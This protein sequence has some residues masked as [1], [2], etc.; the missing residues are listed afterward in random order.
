MV[1]IKEIAVD[2]AYARVV[3]ETNKAINLLMALQPAETNAPPK[4]KSPVV[5]NKSPRWRPTDLI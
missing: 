3:I 1:S 5:A 2:N 4:T